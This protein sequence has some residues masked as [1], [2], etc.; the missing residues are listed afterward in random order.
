LTFSLNDKKRARELLRANVAKV[1]MN[2][3]E[4][5]D[6]DAFEGV[7]EAVLASESPTQDEI[8]QV[9]KASLNKARAAYAADRGV[10]PTN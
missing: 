8:L 7:L 5:I 3:V 10:G 9:F 4:Y 1:D 6:W 2:A